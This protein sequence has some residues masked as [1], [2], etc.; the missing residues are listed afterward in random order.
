VTN[1]KQEVQEATEPTTITAYK[2][3][4]ANMQCRGYQFEVGNTYAHDGQV[5]A[6][7]SGFHSCEYPLDVLYYYSPAT[8]LFAEVEASGSL[9]RHEEDSKVASSSLTIKASIDL[10]GIIKAAI[11]YTMS[12]TKPAESASNSGDRGAA[13]NSGYRGAASNGGYRGAAS[14][15]GD[16]GVAADFNGYYSKARSCATGAIICINRDEDG[17]IR[18]IRASKV[19]ENG[20]KPD[21]WYALNDSGEFIES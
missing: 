13:S 16:S 10:P 20:I 3:F 12:R 14:N 6:C 18:H 2:G 17:N 15:S 5:E 21:T 4:D 7:K 8:S 19:G 9:S 11:E 1:A